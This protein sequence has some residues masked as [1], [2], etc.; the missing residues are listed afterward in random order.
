MAKPGD[1]ALDGYW[2]QSLYESR[3]D[4]SGMVEDRGLYGTSLL[5]ENQSDNSAR[6]NDEAMMP[7]IDSL[8]LVPGLLEACYRLRQE[9]RARTTRSSE[10]QSLPMKTETYVPPNFE[11]PEYYEVPLHPEQAWAVHRKFN[12]AIAAA[13][14]TAANSLAD[15]TLLREW[16]RGEATLLGAELV[17][18]RRELVSRVATHYA[19]PEVK[20]DL[21]RS[22]AITLTL[23]TGLPVMRSAETQDLGIIADEYFGAEARPNTRTDLGTNLWRPVYK[24]LPPDDVRKRY[25]RTITNADAPG[26]R[27]LW[28]EWSDDPALNRSPFAKR[29]EVLDQLYDYRTAEDWRKSILSAH[30][31]MLF[32]QREFWGEWAILAL[33][34]AI[35]DT[36][37]GL[38]F[39]VIDRFV[40]NVLGNLTAANTQLNDGLSVTYWFDYVDWGDYVPLL[41]LASG[42]L[43]TGKDDPL[44]AVLKREI[45]PSLDETSYTDIAGYLLLAVG[46]GMLIA[47]WGSATLLAAPLAAKGA[48]VLFAME[49]AVSSAG[50]GL[51]AKDF[52]DALQSANQDGL[53][54]LIAELDPKL[55]AFESTSSV[56]MATGAMLL[57]VLLT[58]LFPP[59]RAFVHGAAR[60]LG[61]ASTAAARNVPPPHLDAPINAR[62]LPDHPHQPTHAGEVLPPNA[63]TDTVAP[64]L[65]ASSR[66]PGMTDEMGEVRATPPSVTNLNN[67]SRGIDSGPL[68]LERHLDPPPISE[69]SLPLQQQ[70]QVLA[71]LQW[72]RLTPK[73]ARFAADM[74]ERYPKLA[75]NGPTVQEVAKWIGSLAPGRTEFG[76]IAATGELSV[77]I[78]LSAQDSVAEITMVASR[79]GQRTPDFDCVLTDGQVISVEVR[80]ITGVPQPGRGTRRP[81]TGDETISIDH[82]QMSFPKTDPTTKSILDSVSNKINH[83]QIG[84]YNSQGYIVVVVDRA[85]SPDLVTPAIVAQIGEMLDTQPHIYGVRILIGDATDQIISIDNPALPLGDSHEALRRFLTDLDSVAEH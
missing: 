24:D 15:R 65:P 57:E 52:Y 80:T 73:Q 58:A 70:L 26:L 54:K 43:I 19:D 6:A 31:I 78:R 61:D 33:C 14:I 63:A 47:T 60:N 18:N 49:I 10:L 50:L 37:D 68:P 56:T 75:R 41:A 85:T 36:D 2:D 13:G 46:V 59:S 84:R 81:R 34:D 40:E 16:L 11:P 25:G 77:L 39:R 12:A 7:G 32:A 8:R 79:S 62:G 3:L 64:D 28:Q 21:S 17:K 9:E 20:K 45:Y 53:E 48:A 71:P 4:D 1:T 38:R 35:R 23:R 27:L 22:L 55:K 74:F 67:T 82:Y 51:A 72:E 76:A 83:D 30:P 69:R 44:F 29:H 42:K 5:S 66:A